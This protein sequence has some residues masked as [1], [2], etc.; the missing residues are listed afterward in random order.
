MCKL[1]LLNGDALEE[2][3]DD[4]GDEIDGGASGGNEGGIPL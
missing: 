4:T 3:N 1:T 2:V